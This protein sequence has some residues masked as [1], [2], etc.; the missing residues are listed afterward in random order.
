MPPGESLPPSNPGLRKLIES[1]RVYDHRLND[2]ARSAGFRGWH[3]RGYL[4][5]YDAPNVTQLVTINLADAFPVKRRAEWEVLLR[6]PDK[7]ESR[8]QLEIWLDRGLGECWLRRP[9]VAA[10]VETEF[11]SKHCREYELRAWTI[12]P[13]H[14]HIVVDVWEVPLSKIIKKW[15]GAAATAANRLLAEPANSGKRTIGTL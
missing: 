10:I 8:R 3:E 7:S 14:C 12:M 9:K 1:K 5:H 15:K 2:E 6:L 13:N 4:P 11:L